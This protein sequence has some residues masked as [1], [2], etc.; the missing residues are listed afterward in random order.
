MSGTVINLVNILEGIISS[1]PAAEALWQRIMPL[2]DKDLEITPEQHAEISAL[3]PIAHAAV[4]TWHAILAAPNP[5][6]AAV[7]PTLAQAEARQQLGEQQQAQ[8]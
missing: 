4:S 6:D 1:L 7:Q 8:G 5:A 2:V 3:T